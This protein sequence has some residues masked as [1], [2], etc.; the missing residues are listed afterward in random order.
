MKKK[1]KTKS[2][3]T[4][5]TKPNLVLNLLIFFMLTIG[6]G[7]VGVGFIFFVLWVVQMI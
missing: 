7:I 6:G 1:I 5:T 4:Y 2:T 3:P